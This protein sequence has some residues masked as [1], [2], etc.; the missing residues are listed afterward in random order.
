MLFTVA[1]CPFHVSAFRHSSVFARTTSNI[2]NCEAELSR[3][4]HAAKQSTI[5]CHERGTRLQMSD[6]SDSAGTKKET[7]WE[8]ITG[9][10]LFKTVT[11]WQGIHSVPL[12][13]LRILTGLLMIHHGSEGVFCQMRRIGRCCVIIGSSVCLSYTIKHFCFYFIRWSGPGKF[14]HPRVSRFHR[15]HRHALLRFLAWAT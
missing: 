10:K 5:E 8:R 9:P 3:T 13:P 11:N 2:K 12:V 4:T 14:W 15:L 7:T 1:L 6:D